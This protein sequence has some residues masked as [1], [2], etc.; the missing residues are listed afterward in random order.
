MQA[1]ARISVDDLVLDPKNPRLPENQ[2][3]GSQVQILTYLN[4][5]DVLDELVDS[6]ISNGFFDNEPL[7][8]L[9]SAPG[10]WTVVEGNRRAAALMRLLGTEVAQ[11]ADLAI[12]ISDREVPVDRLEELATVP[13]YQLDD[14]NEVSRYIGFRHISGLKTWG[15]EAKARYLWLQVEDAA[16]S[17]AESPFFVVGRQVGSNAAGVRTAYNAFNL[18]RGAE[19]LGVDADVDYVKRHRFGVWTR[20]LGTANVPTYMGIANDRGA[21]Y[22]EV[23]ERAEQLIP[24]R[25]AEVLQDLKPREGKRSAVLKDSRDVTDYSDVLGNPRAL[26]V[27]REYDNLA[28]AVQVISEGQLGERLSALIDAVEVLTREVPRLEVPTSREFAQARELRVLTRALLG[29]IESRVE[30]DDDEDDDA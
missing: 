7:L 29:V 27:M 13:A 20:L 23:K 12:D 4:E 9:A 28:L 19:H 18:L 1:L 16:S 10:S 24:T 26:A 15:A 3:G 30:D 5:H 8:V 11:D 22:A 2:Q 17:G 14:R 21:G 6:Y 25:A